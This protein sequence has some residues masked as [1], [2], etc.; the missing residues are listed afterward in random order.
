M[1]VREVRPPVQS[2]IHF[3][4][5]TGAWGLIDEQLPPPR[6]GIVL[7]RSVLGARLMSVSQGAF[8]LQ[9]VGYGIQVGGP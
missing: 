4:F 1:V 5:A 8:D 2:T 9:G 6:S 3:A 7:A